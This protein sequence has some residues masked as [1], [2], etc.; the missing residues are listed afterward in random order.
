MKKFILIAI[1]SFACVNSSI[2]QSIEKD[3]LMDSITPPNPVSNIKPT[4]P[5]LKHQWVV[6]K[7]DGEGNYETYDTP[8]VWMLYKVSNK[9]FYYVR[10]LSFGYLNNGWDDLVGRIKLQFGV[11]NNLF[12]ECS[13]A[14]TVKRGD[15]FRKWLWG[16]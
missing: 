15:N 3:K 10:Q 5:Y 6:V 13:V 14:D 16:F 12:P 11:S 7:R 1:V 8:S 4:E 2:G 9:K